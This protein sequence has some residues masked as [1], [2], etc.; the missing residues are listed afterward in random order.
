MLSG[1]M[2]ILLKQPMGPFSTRG[3]AFPKVKIVTGVVAEEVLWAIVNPLRPNVGKEVGKDRGI[4]K[5]LK[6]CPCSI[7]CYLCLCVNYP[8][9][10][11]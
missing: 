9:L 1:N 8:A 11:A 5:L 4:I 2:K 3:S 6:P 10:A 7:K